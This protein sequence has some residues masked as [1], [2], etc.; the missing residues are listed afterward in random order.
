MCGLSIRAP[1]REGGESM[2]S[3]TS[4]GIWTHVPEVGGQGGLSVPPVWRRSA[5]WQLW[6]RSE[7]VLPWDQPVLPAS[8]R[9]QKA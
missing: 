7:G 4:T 8:V 2:V 6:C 5:G 3:L 1:S 9:L